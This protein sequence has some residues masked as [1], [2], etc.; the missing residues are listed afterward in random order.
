M[1][2]RLRNP[3]PP[4]LRCPLIGQIERRARNAPCQIEERE[5]CRGPASHH[6]TN[7]GCSQHQ[8]AD[9]PNGHSKRR[10]AVLDQL[11]A[12]QPFDGRHELRRRPPISPFA[13]CKGDFFADH[14]TPRT[15]KLTDMKE[16]P[17]FGLVIDEAKAA[18]IVPL[19]DCA[20][21]LIDGLHRETPPQ[22]IC[23]FSPNLITLSAVSWI[24][25][26]API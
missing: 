26:R 15:R 23:S 3:P 7:D 13:K 2:R 16:D 5:P 12:K 19:A 11:R 18:S 14:R 9:H 1:Q 6:A 20:T 4:L 8:R 17:P 25:W 10:I 24:D 22:L 21:M